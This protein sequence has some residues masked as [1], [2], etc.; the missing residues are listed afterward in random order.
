MSLRT[1]LYAAATL[2]LMLSAN[3]SGQVCGTLPNNL[4]GRLSFRG[5]GW[6][7]RLRPP[8]ELRDGAPATAELDI[9]DLLMV[10]RSA[11]MRC[12]AGV[13]VLT[14][15]FGFG[16][17]VLR[18]DSAG[19]V[20]GATLLAGDSLRVSLSQSGEAPYR[21][22][23]VSFQNGD[24]R[25]AGSLYIPEGAGPHPGIV[26][27]HGS[28]PQGRGMLEYRSWG[29]YLARRGLATLVYDKRG[30]GESGGDFRNDSAFVGL[31]GDV[32]AAVDALRRNPSVDGARVGLGGA[33]QAGWIAYRAGR[34][35]RVAFL[36]LLVP[37]SVSVAEQEIARVRDHMREEGFA[38]ADVAMAVAH[39]RLLMGVAVTGVGWEGL[40]A[41]TE[42]VADEPWAEWVQRPEG[43]GDLRWWR[44]HASIDPRPDL[45][46]LRIP[47]F[48]AFS[49][50]DRVVS[51][52]DNAG[53]L[54]ELATR[55]PGADI[56]VVTA[57]RGNHRL[58]VPA[59]TG[60]DG[61]WHLPR[62]SR[63]VL[64]ALDTW[65]E[66]RWVH[67]TPSAPARPRP[68]SGS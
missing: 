64:S 58:E 40:A 48:A 50:G 46:A 53:P 52:L 9:P 24:I 27:V 47:I 59:G 6:T 7:L 45:E 36:A 61:R 54:R 31:T 55:T 42:H 65:I 10:G 57:P 16:D 34:D 66:V 37:P 35:P 8:A 14:L 32:L 33:S 28:G 4:E 2:C 63:E 30:V 5:D 67:R 68:P 29:D 1:P 21:V 51:A 56:T 13:A 49:S 17:V 12:D 18:A 43:M 26:M 41:S 62:V 22:E 20:R 19:S 39:T 3:A 60:P 11:D 15:P 38:E 23:E 25:L 44:D